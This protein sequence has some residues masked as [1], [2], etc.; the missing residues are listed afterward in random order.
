MPFPAGITTRLVTLGPGTT[1]EA[2]D[3][4]GVKATVKSSRDLVWSATGTAVRAVEK[5]YEN[6]AG[7]ELE[8]PLPVTDQAG[9]LLNGAV[10]DV[11]DG[12]Q[13]HYYVISLEFYAEGVARPV[14]TATLGPI[15]LP[16]G[17]GSPIDADKL[18]PA[19]TQGGATI[20]LP[21]SWSEAVAL[22]Q[23]AAAEAAAAVVD[24]EAFVRT[25]VVTD[26][27]DPETDIGGVLLATIDASSTHAGFVLDDPTETVT[28][29]VV[30]I[31]SIAGVPYG[32]HATTGGLYKSINDGVSWTQIKETGAY[33]SLHAMGNGEIILNGG[34]TLYRTTGW[35]AD[36]AT[37]TI[38]ACLTS[39][40]TSAFIASDVDT[41]ENLVLAAEYCVPRTDARFVKLSTD[42]GVT[43]TTVR[44][45][46][47]MFP[48]D[49]PGTHWHAVCIDG[50]HAG[51]NPRLW[52]SHGDGPRGVYYSD[53]LGTSWTEYGVTNTW[54]P[55][56]MMATPNGIV[57]STDQNNPDGVWLIPR[58]LSPKK[59]LARIPARFWSGALLGFGVAATRDETTGIVYI[60][61]RA[62]QQTYF[63]EPRPALIFAT[64]GVRASILY[65][66]ANKGTVGVGGSVNWDALPAITKNGYLLASYITDTAPRTTVRGR[67]R[68]GALSQGQL[69]TGNVLTGVAN[70]RVATAIGYGVVA[71]NQAVV[72]GNGAAQAA[73]TNEGDVL[74][75]TEAKGA[76]QSVAAGYRADAKA[77]GV[78]LGD[79]ATNSLGEAISIG[80]A[81]TTTGVHGVAIGRQATAA[82]LGT[83]VGKGAI[84]HAGGAAFGAAAKC[85]T[86]AA[87]AIGCIAD[88][89]SAVAIGDWQTWANG[90][91]AIA[92][93][94]NAQASGTRATAIGEGSR[95]LHQDSV[96]L[97]YGAVTTGQRQLAIGPVNVELIEFGSD[98]AAPAPNG[99]RFFARDNGAGKTQACVRFATGAIK[100]LATED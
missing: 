94:A 31:G 70:D 83:A 40:G 51:P 30:P 58:N 56:P 10:V 20:S 35:A 32:R 91:S 65:A 45:L 66:T 50:Y 25:T 16:T 4:L 34:G 11:A 2:G 43:W 39:N 28:P 33:Y 85:R 75:G 19:T 71:H 72:I 95:G 21:D 46:D 14:S 73:S 92:L 41:Y 38:T 67:V 48:S 24:S 62:D 12:K 64:D 86:T 36:P 37:A 29:G 81:A 79:T 3:A 8:F 61:F 49:K 6:E 99:M 80:S 23:A 1:M 60:L 68:R 100:I 22:A 96:A 17:D 69:D 77:H 27:P 53:D 88:G 55:M 52:A 98:P 54:Q 84:A 47:V 78:A 87:V 42:F 9:W 44:D 93:G 97:G 63:T 13:S 59:L 57:V 26:I 18:I 5:T 90:N 76:G 15:A 82:G 74:I 89:Y 7:L